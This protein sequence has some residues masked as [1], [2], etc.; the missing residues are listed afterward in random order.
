VGATFDQ[1]LTLELA[2]HP[3]EVPSAAVDYVGSLVKVDRGL[4]GQYYWRGRTV[5]RQRAQMRKAYGTRPPT[6]ADEDR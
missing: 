4:F 2:D 3:E 1:P 5:E 6:E